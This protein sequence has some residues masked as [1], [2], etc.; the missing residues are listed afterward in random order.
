M[1]APHR[2]WFRLGWFR[3]CLGD[4]K[5]PVLLNR[6]PVGELL[7]RFEHAAPDGPRAPLRSVRLPEVRNAAVVNENRNGVVGGW[8]GHWLAILDQLDGK[9]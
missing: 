2:D 1:R 7:E 4:G 8:N 9:Q 6:E 5:L 3:S